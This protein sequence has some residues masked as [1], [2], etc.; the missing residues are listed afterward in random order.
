[1]CFPSA[2]S[3]DHHGGWRTE[4]SF[5]DLRRTEEL[6]S[7]IASPQPVRFLKHLGDDFRLWIGHAR[8][9]PGHD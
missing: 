6:Q 9:L 3:I 5:D 8:T 7:T 4:V 2:T 1:M